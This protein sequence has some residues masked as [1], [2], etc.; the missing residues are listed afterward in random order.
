MLRL[1]LGLLGI[2]ATLFLS[3]GQEA[4][5]LLRFPLCWW[6][7]LLALSGAVRLVRGRSPFPSLGSFFACAAASVVF[8]DVFELLNLRLRNWWYVGVS[9]DPLAGALFAAFSFATVLPAAR[10]GLALLTPAGAGSLESPN[11]A[12]GPRPLTLTL[13][14][15][16]SL[17]LALRFPRFA[18]PLAWIFLWPLCEAALGALQQAPGLESPLEAL[19]RGHRGLILRL[20]ALA[21][22]LGLVWE[23][24]NSGCERGWVYTVPFFEQP[25]LFEM[26]LP[27][28]L[29]YLPFLLEAG[30]ALAL[31]ERLLPRLYGS[32]AAAALAAVAVFHLGADRLGH[33]GTVLSNTPL[34][35]QAR[36][37]DAAGLEAQGLRTP[38]EVMRA[39]YAPGY[40]HAIAELAQ[41][42][43]VSVPMAE[44]LVLLGVQGPADL[45]KADP[46]SLHGRLA[47]RLEPP[48]LPVVRLWIQAASRSVSR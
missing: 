35:S 27:G 45:A 28:Y 20:L 7:L 15:L 21:L 26:P 24:L 16:V 6:S 33:Q 30:A 18:F 40:A 1:A 13:L 17:L 36:T 44:Q 4:I 29:G 10:Y 19:R 25:K 47:R 32:R 41:V 42:S 23:S 9:P 5:D 11:P 37:L 48:P 3:R 46:A 31:V 39:K 43:G 22:P 8:W 12:R 2:A 34:L 14:G 38:R